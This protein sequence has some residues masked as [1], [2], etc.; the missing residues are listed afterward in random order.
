MSISLD[1][2]RVKSVEFDKVVERDSHSVRTIVITTETGEEFELNLHASDNAPGDS[3]AAKLKF[4][5]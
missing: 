5:I 1:I 4:Q 2:M 3:G